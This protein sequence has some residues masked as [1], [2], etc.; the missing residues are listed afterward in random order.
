MER[1][2][3]GER[4]LITRRGRPYARFLPPQDQLAAEPSLSPAAT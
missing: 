4:I 1:A 3:A 2:C